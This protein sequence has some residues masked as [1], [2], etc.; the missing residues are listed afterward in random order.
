[1]CTGKTLILQIAQLDC[2]L[3]FTQL[4]RENNY[5]RPTLDES[6]AI[7]IKEGR[8]PVIEKQLP[9]GESYVTNDVYL[10]S[11]DLIYIGN[12]P[13]LPEKSLKLLK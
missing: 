8:H 3:G 4:A 7:D 5:V 11:G 10:D 6:Q 13:P 12:L 9:L 1:M 2:L